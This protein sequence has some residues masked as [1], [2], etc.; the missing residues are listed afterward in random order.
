MIGKHQIKLGGELRKAQLDEFYHR[1]ALGIFTFDG[2]QGPDAANPNDSW[3]AGDPRVDALADFLSGRIS[4]ASI[5]L[6]DPDRQVFVNTWDLFAED[7]WQ[8]TAKFNVNFGLRW[9]YEGPLHNSYKNLSVF[10]PSL[11]GTGIAV[12]GAQISN[13]FDPIYTDFSPRVGFSYQLGPNT[14]VRAGAGLYYDTPNLNPFLDNRPGNGAPNG[15]EGNPTGPGSVHTT[16][17]NGVTIQDGVDVFNSGT[18]PSQ[19]SLF[20]VAP[21]FVPSHNM[22]FNFQLEQS[23]TPKVVAQLGYVGSEARHLLSILDINQA[24]LSATGDGARPYDGE[25]TDG[26]GDPLYSFI[27]QIE[28]IGTSNYNSLQATVRV[29]SIHGLSGQAAY[30]W[31]HSN[32]EV[33]AYRGALPQD[34]TNFK[35][36]YGPSD[37]DERNIFTGLISWDVPG[38]HVMPVLTKGWQVNSLLTFHGGNPFSVY[39]SADTS[40]TNDGNQRANLVPGV[41]PY[42]GFR[43]GAVNA[44]WLNPAAFVDAPAGTWGTTSRNEFVGPGYGDVDLS[45]FKNTKV[46]ERVTAQFRVEMFNLLNKTNYAPPL[47]GSDS[48]NPNYTYDNALQLFTTIGNFNGAPGIGAGEP[49]NTQFALKLI[50]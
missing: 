34:S 26:V 4:N 20:S 14:V 45:V 15:V 12:Q 50:F 31:S 47:G 7:A 17:V 25:F 39:S 1:H 35:G 27:N 8:A 38:A 22:N 21:N 40:G 32:D 24:A 2:S 9:D 44:N 30:T 13:L 5:A 16:T 36:D 23:L 46:G 28:S 18:T 11:G 29:S 3:D 33:T 19:N 42:A 41:S 10:R 43:K 37:F 48:F 49:Y 6:G